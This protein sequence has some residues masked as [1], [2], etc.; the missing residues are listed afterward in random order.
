MA[1]FGVMW[2][3]PVCQGRA[4][5]IC[6]LRKGIE[7]DFLNII[8]QEA[9]EF[10]EAG[11]TGLRDCPSCSQRMPQAHVPVANKEQLT[12][13]VCLPCHFIWL[14]AGEAALLPPKEISLPPP[15]NEMPLEAREAIALATIE[16][17]RKRF[18]REE[19]VRDFIPDPMGIDIWR[20]VFTWLF[21]Q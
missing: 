12:V 4:V 2:Q 19:K 10:S 18:D 3:C 21:R 16:A 9:R 7:G 1:G 8:W 14:D 17:Q 11:H 6:L 5:T 15:T 20:L 13:D